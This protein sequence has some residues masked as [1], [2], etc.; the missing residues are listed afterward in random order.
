M[1]FQPFAR[2]VRKLMGTFCSLA[3]IIHKI[4][5]LTVINLIERLMLQIL[6]IR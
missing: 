6:G 2:N 5:Y 3:R 1:D 4:I